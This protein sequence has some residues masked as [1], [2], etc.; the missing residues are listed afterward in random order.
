MGEGIGEKMAQILVK[1]VFLLVFLYACGLRPRG[2]KQI[3]AM[4]T[5]MVVLALVNHGLLYVAV[6]LFTHGFLQH[7]R[8]YTID[9]SGDMLFM[10]KLFSVLFAA[11]LAVYAVL[12]LLLGAEHTIAVLVL[13]AAV[14]FI[15]S[16]IGMWASVFWLRHKRKREVA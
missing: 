2:A 16:G 4:V 15:G 10:P 3:S 9:T 13:F 1:S 14:V 6:Y 8:V 7:H 12:R 5:L 11:A